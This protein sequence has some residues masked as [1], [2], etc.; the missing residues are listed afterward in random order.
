MTRDD[1]PTKI[2]LK[3][4]QRVGYRCSIPACRIITV[5]PG[6]ESQESVNNI[7]MA[8]HIYGAVDS[9]NSPR[10]N[11]EMTTA[12]RKSIENGIWTCRNCGTK[13]DN[14]V[15]KDKKVY[16]FIYQGE[17]LTRR[18]LLDWSGPG[19]FGVKRNINDI[20]YLP[21]VTDDRKLITSLV[22]DENAQRPTAGGWRVRGEKIKLEDIY[23]W[24]YENGE[25]VN[26]SY[27]TREELK[28]ICSI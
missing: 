25:I 17:G 5:G 14:D 1:F 27:Q 24:N 13:I 16:L 12:E 26:T 7:G 23:S 3:L 2:K 15:P 10:S 18:M 22:C 4:A 28:S 6:E 21:V 8:S 20:D 19:A 11:A 9:P